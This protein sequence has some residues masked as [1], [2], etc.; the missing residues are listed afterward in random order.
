MGSVLS[1]LPKSLHSKA[2]ADLQTIWIART[3]KEAQATPKRFIK[4][5]GD[6]YPKAAERLLKDRENQLA[7]SG[8]R[9]PCANVRC[10]PKGDIRESDNVKNKP[11]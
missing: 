5:Y 11:T 6:M 1:A 2:K 9:R 3:R 4:R 10:R 7:A 8:R